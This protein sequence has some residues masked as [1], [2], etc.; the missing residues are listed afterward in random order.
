MEKSLSVVF[1]FALAI[2]VAIAIFALGPAIASGSEIVMPSFSD[3][4]GEQIIKWVG[5]AILIG[6][7]A[8]V[9]FKLMNG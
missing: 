7:P 3:L 6:V 9:V 5:V 1:A 2:V 8:T 4:G